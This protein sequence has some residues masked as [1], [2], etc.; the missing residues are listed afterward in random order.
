MKCIY[1]L[2]FFIKEYR[3]PYIFLDL[4]YGIYIFVNLK[5]GLAAAINTFKWLK[6]SWIYEIKA[7]TYISVIDLEKTSHK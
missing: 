5:L 3:R 6:M 1:L 7:T 2:Q 4:S